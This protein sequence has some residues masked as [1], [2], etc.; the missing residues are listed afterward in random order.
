MNPTHHYPSYAEMLTSDLFSTEANC[1]QYLLDIG[2]LPQQRRCYTCSQWMTIRPCFK[3]LYREGSCWKCCDNTSSLRSGSIL[4]D[5]KITYRKFI[6]I[7]AEFSRDSTVSN[8]SATLGVSE[9]TVR[10]FY[11]EIR[12]RMAEDIQSCELLGGPGR[13][14]EVDE[15]KFGKRKFN[16]GRIVDGSWVCGGIERGTNLCF[17]AVCPDNIRNQPTLLRLI[18]RYVAPGTTIITDKWKGYIN[19]GNHG[20]VHEDVNHLT[21]FVDPVSGAHTNGIE[22]TWTHVKNR[23]LRRGG[24]RTPDSLDADLTNF[25]WLRQKQLTSGQ[26]KQR[27]LFAKELPLL[28]NFKYY[29]KV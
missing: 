15:A 17:L 16:T 23:V 4:Q 20:Y 8:A 9:R 27:L 25:M 13:V 21:N 12:E 26:H 5:K 22:G 24:R 14:V 7:L 28:L 11:G 3:A 29:L 6:D 18:Q 19:L 2:I 10:F 1:C